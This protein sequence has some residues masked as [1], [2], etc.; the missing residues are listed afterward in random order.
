M[1]DTTQIWD[2]HHRFET[3]LN[4]S[5]REL[6]NRDL[7]YNRPASELIFLTHSEHSKLH[8]KAKY[9]SEEHKRKLSEAKKGKPANNRGKHHT[10]EA[11]RKMKEALKGRIFINNGLI[12]KMIR[13]EE[14]DY[15]ISLGYTKGILKHK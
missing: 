2:C 1:N 5:M 8:G 11:K 3:D 12:N 13:K 10:E 9:F 14:L 6:K 7:Y 15:Y 4:L